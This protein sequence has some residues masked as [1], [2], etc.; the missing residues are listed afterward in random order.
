VLVVVAS[1]R[2][3]VAANTVA[4]WGGE[5]ARLLTC[6]DLSVNG[7]RYR[8]GA[9]SR[10]VA[11]IGGQRVHASEIEGVLVRLPYVPTDELPHIMPG[12]RGY[13]AQE[14]TAF[15]AAWLAELPCPVLNRPTAACLG[16]PGW[17]A[18]Q[19]LQL[20]ARLGIAVRPRHIRLAAGSSTDAAVQPRPRMTVTVIGARGFGSA[21]ASAMDQAQRL[22]DAADVGL[23][24]VHFDTTRAGLRFVGV[25]PW[26]DVSRPAVADA[27]REQLLAA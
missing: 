16:G 4:C 23:L 26:P 20:A 5:Q 14:M 13:V 8:P 27:L 18:E 24:D 25:D 10:C 2:D 12:D 6:R 1:S 9:V 11:M 19:W 3:R 7:W 22:A 15:L 21:P 17:S